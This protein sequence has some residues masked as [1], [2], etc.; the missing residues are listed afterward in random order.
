MVR[1]GSPSS[2]SEIA[3]LSVSSR[4]APRLRL[5]TLALIA[6][7]ALAGCAPTGELKV[8]GQ[9][10][11][12]PVPTVTALTAES[13]PITGGTT[14]TITGTDLAD[15]SS[16][17]FGKVKAAITSVKKTSV[18]V[19]AP[20]AAKYKKGK[21]TVKVA[22]ASG[23]KLSFHYE[24]ASGLDKQLAYV[25]AHWTTR[26]LDEYGEIADNDCVNFTSQSLI[27][28]GWTMD[29]DWWHSQEGGVN[30]YATAW[31]SS[32]AMMDYLGDHPE[33]V[34]A[35]TDDQRSKVR[36]GDIVQFD[37]DNSGDRDHT[38]IVT[39]ITGTGSK[40]KIFFAGHTLDSDFRSVD[41][42]IT[43]DHPGGTAYYWHLLK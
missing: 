23:E 14:V 34:T 19:T 37:W 3:V 7:L 33:L 20:A 12:D 13:G 28:R 25:M 35:L 18:T 2:H 6:G 31:I 39:R 30:S 42:A 1:R 8:S 15:T 4:R 26:N 10:V 24:V 41:T 29:D 36:V 21:V 22:G 16:V 40:T 5:L 38:G 9:K 17:K 11:A 27:A 43:K 32:T